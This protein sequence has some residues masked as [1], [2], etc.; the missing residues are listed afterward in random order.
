[1]TSA[2]GHTGP[3]RLETNKD[4]GGARLPATFTLRPH[5]AATS[6]PT[7]KKVPPATASPIQSSRAPTRSQP[8]VQH[9]QVAPALARQPHRQGRPGRVSPRGLTP[10][11]AATVAASTTVAAVGQR[12]RAVAAAATAVAT[13]LARLRHGRRGWVATRHTPKPEVRVGE[14][15][16]KGREGGGGERAARK[17]GPLTRGVNAAGGGRGEKQLRVSA[18]AVVGP[19]GG[20]KAKKKE[21]KGK[22][23]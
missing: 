16:G 2:G 23:R 21:D 10:A 7:K 11:A 4:R 19:P 12:R 15:A 3:Q 5:G 17:R 13:P 6:P 20:R 22:E 18:A 14:E 8:H 1:M 9:N